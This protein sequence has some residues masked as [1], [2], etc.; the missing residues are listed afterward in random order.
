MGKREIELGSGAGVGPFDT[1]SGKSKE[2]YNLSCW[3]WQLTINNSKVYDG[4]WSNIHD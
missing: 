2:I 3:N 4:D 1:V